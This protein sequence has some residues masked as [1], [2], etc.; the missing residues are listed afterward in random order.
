[1]DK[2]TELN[3][4]EKAD[5]LLLNIEVIIFVIIISSFFMI[6]FLS[7]YIMSELQIYLV[8]AL[9]ILFDF[10]LFILGTLTCIYIEKKAGYYECKKCHNKYEPTFSQSLLALHLG[11]TKYLR[12]PQC[13]Q[14]S[15]NKKVLK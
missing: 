11:R 3:S 4:K 12:C 1:M 2:N 5:K 14:K 8:P 7:A 6:L 9:L 10:V 13:N 15:W